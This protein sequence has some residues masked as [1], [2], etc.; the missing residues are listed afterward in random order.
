M[1]NVCPIKRCS[2]IVPC[3]V[4][5]LIGIGL[6]YWHSLQPKRV[7][8]EHTKTVP[9]QFEYLTRRINLSSPGNKQLSAEEAREDLDEI[10]RLLE[11]HYSYLKLKGVDYRAALD[12]IRNSLG[13][14]I[15][16]S[17]F[18]YQLTKFL[19]LFGDGHSRVASSTVRLKSLC[20]A[21]LPFLVEESDGRLVAFKPDRSDFV[22]VD[23][24]FL[25]QMDGFPV[26][27]WLEVASQYVAK[28]SPQYLRYRTIRNLR[29]VECLRKE[30]GL[31]K[32]TSIQVELESADGSSTRQ[33]QLPLAKK[34]PVYGFWP[35][36]ENEIKSRKDIHLES[37]ILTGNIGYLRFVF[38]PAEPEFLKDLVETM[39]RFAKTE[40]LIIDIRANSGGRRAPL[41]VLF[42]F[43]MAENDL[44]RVVNIAAYRLGTKNI[45]EDFEARYLYSASSQHWST[46]ERDTIARF[47]DTFEPQ[48]SLPQ[49][50]FSEWHYFVISPAQDQGYFHYDKPV[51]IL[52]DRW[53]FSACDI[54]LGAF[55]GW[56]NI[57]LMGQPSGGGS[58]CYQ[59]YRLR[60]S[61][62]RICLSSM[63]SFQPNGKLYDGN[64]IQPD[65]M[66]EPI[67][68]DFIGKTDTILEAAIHRLQQIQST[69]KNARIRHQ[70]W[71][72][73]ACQP[74]IGPLRTSAYP[75]IVQAL[76]SPNSLFA[77]QA[78]KKT[79]HLY[80]Q[81]PKPQIRYSNSP[82]NVGKFHTFH[83]N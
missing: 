6:W 16:R 46:V 63:A 45:K 41:R 31:N 39:N 27:A 44:P 78:T 13:D 43:F 49:E 9:K 72:E 48:W 60:N 73:C 81:M 18:G 53:N 79:L 54:F 30:F 42:P 69:S 25:R 38:M 77:F 12:S 19:A 11:N 23:F 52:M 22:N 70:L 36:P 40:G 57:T 71:A 26:S 15:S 80:N 58:G 34:G 59:E 20:S 82:E 67:P 47:A 24:P 17:D 65:V 50:E 74:P 4:I 8:R 76:I 83:E 33:I 37:R 14:G 1:K 5:I 35:R 61:Y 28:G 3:A 32:S 21:F 68:T 64:S 29:Y 62:I 55:K 56:K 10:E 2:Y 66:I 51:V 75:L 7:S